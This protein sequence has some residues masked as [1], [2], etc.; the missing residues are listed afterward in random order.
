[1]LGS[2]V[3]SRYASSNAANTSAARNAISGTE[4]VRLPQRQHVLELMGQFAD[5]PETASGRVPLQRVHRPPQAARR[6]RVPRRL[7]QPH[8]FVVQLLHQFPRGFEEQL[9]QFAHSVFGRDGHIFTS[10]RW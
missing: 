3:P 7:L 1:M 10:T 8:R 9:A 6:L 2:F 5:F 4:A